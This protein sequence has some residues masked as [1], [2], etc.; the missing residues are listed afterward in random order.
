VQL[1]ENERGN[2]VGKTYTVLMTD[3]PAQVEYDDLAIK[4]TLIG[5]TGIEDP[6]RDGIWPSLGGRC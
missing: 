2:T 3:W 6:L 1:L 4:L 5:I